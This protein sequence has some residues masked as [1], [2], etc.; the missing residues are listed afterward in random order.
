MNISYSFND[1]YSFVAGV[2]VISLFESNQ[3]LEQINVYILG[4]EISELNKQR[5]YSIATKYGRTIKFLDVSKI[6]AYLDNCGIRLIPKYKPT[7]YRLFLDMALPDDV[8]SVLFLD[9]DTL[10]IGS[11]AELE[12]YDFAQDT[13]CAMVRI[14]VFK[15]YNKYI[16][17]ESDLYYNAGVLLINM[18]YWKSQNI[19]NRIKEKI[20]SGQTHFT[21]LDQ[22]LLI[23]S[24]SGHIQTL[25][26]GYNMMSFYLDVSA[27]RYIKYKRIDE[28]VF[29]TSDELENAIQNPIIL[30]LM[31][32]HLGQ[33]WEQG[34]KHPYRNEWL[35]CKRISPWS[36]VPQVKRKL[37]IRGLVYKTLF[38]LLP[39]AL[40][41]RATVAIL[42]LAVWK[43]SR[44]NST[45]G[46]NTHSSKGEST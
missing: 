7:Y 42:K 10:I 18:N 27:E 40:Y 46:I 14:H 28:S 4:S 20:N 38:L 37:N 13:A 17:V 33:P 35:E 43:N 45:S 39:K 5:F 34:N 31:R 44:K 32:G 25:P 26:A 16:G 21:A 30:H 12:N 23:S 36:G 19:T 11:L 22:D 29:Y 41:Y 8:E 3:D 6:D 1:Q 15:N 2:S 24:V 9:S